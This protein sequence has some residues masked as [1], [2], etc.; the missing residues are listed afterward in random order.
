MKIDPKIY[1]AL[2]LRNDDPVGPVRPVGDSDR[3]LMEDISK[4]LA[5]SG[6]ASSVFSLTTGFGLRTETYPLRLPSVLVPGLRMME[7]LLALGILPPKYIIYQVT[8]FIAKTCPFSTQKA[9]EIGESMRAYLQ[10]YID[11]FHPAIKDYVVLRFADG[12]T[13]A[14]EAL[15]AYGEAI[16][17][18][19]D[20]SDDATDAFD[21][22]RGYCRNALASQDAWVT[23]SAANAICNGVDPNCYPFVSELTY[24]QPYIMLLG[25]DKE[26]PFFK[27]TQALQTGEGPQIIGGIVRPGSLPTYYG[28]P[29]GDITNADQCRLEQIRLMPGPVREDF[30]VLEC[31]GATPKKLATLHKRYVA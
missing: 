14:E 6:D 15:Q 9:Q 21:V 7:R 27:V 10:A 13:I 25:G 20:A 11:L 1:Q 4:E 8:D 28:Y 23:Y 19:V 16:C 30:Y 2:M 24:K 22:L 26:T 18:M 5:N 12:T 29:K 3:N 31:D 17:R